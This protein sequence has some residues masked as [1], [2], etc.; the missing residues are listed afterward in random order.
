MKKI[1]F[2]EK[3]YNS[4]SLEKTADYY[5]WRLLH[6]VGRPDIYVLI[7]SEGSDQLEI[8]HAS[9]LFQPYYR[10]HPPT[11]A[12]FAS[13]YDEA[14]AICVSLA[15]CVYHDTGDADIKGFLK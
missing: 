4:E 11:V 5:R 2:L 15:A 8:M 7:L 3:M 6:R 13:T 12:G 1:R 14:V 10:E 9:G